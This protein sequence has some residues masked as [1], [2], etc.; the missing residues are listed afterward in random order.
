M[1]R[2]LFLVCLIGGLCSLGLRA[3]DATK[4]ETIEWLKSKID[5]SQV[6]FSMPGDITGTRFISLSI[7]DEG[8]IV[9]KEQTVAS[10]PDLAYNRSV[11]LSADLSAMSTEVTVS[12]NSITGESEVCMTTPKKGGV[13]RRLEGYSEGD[14][15]PAHDGQT[16]WFKIGSGEMA[17]RVAK[18]L[19]HL[20]RLSGGKAEPF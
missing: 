5:G 12:Q 19:A 14:F 18:A 6:S 11:I 4:A 2:T 1:K 20:I 9:S 13:T 3:E 17:N 16:F 8:R 7:S 10:G 15:I